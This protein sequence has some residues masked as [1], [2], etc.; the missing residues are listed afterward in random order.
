MPVLKVSV[1]PDVL[2]GQ[3]CFEG[4][5]TPV[6]VLFVNLAAGERLDVILDGYPGVTHEAAVTVLREAL[7]LVRER[8]FAE[9]GISPE[10]QAK[11]G[12]VMFPD[13]W[14]ALALDERQAHYRR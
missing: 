8:A 4:T 1:R 6:D 14:E 3:P 13:D 7:R 12:A 5:Q 9:A 2:N 11:A 10:A